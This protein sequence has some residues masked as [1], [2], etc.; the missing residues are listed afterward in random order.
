MM[1]LVMN[2]WERKARTKWWKLEE[3]GQECIVRLTEYIESK[4]ASEWTSGNTYHKPVELVKEELG[5]TSGGKYLEKV[6]VLKFSDTGNSRAE[7]CRF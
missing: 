5:E 6:L 1:G 2:S 4:E 7:T 3:E